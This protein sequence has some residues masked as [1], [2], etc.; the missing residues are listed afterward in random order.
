MSLFLTLNTE[1]S[2][3]LGNVPDVT[4][5]ENARGAAIVITPDPEPRPDLKKTGIRVPP[6]PDLPSLDLSRKFAPQL[7]RPA[8][9]DVVFGSGDNDPGDIDF[10]E[11]GIPDGCDLLCDDHD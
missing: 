6:P 5:P 4:Y 11:L 10:D 9:S 3:V 1:A 8:T 7:M 2:V